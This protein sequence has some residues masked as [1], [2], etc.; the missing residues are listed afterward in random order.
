MAKKLAASNLAFQAFEG[1]YKNGNKKIQDSCSKEHKKGD[2][3][4]KPS[5]ELNSL[6]VLF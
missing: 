2:F 1:H 6:F 4:K 3:L 5:R